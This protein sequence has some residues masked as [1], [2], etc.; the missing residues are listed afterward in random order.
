MYP[1]V[2]KLTFIVALWLLANLTH[3]LW[4]GLRRRGWEQGLTRNADGLLLDALPWSSGHGTT[5][6]LMI[7]GFAD[8]PAVFRMLAA[9]L[10]P[11]QLHCHAMR[12]PG[13]GDA[14]QVAARQ[15]T[16]SL[17]AAIQHEIARLRTSHERVW[18]LGHSLGGG[19]ALLTQLRDP[20]AADGLLLLAPL[21][22]V[23][24]ARSPLLPPHLWFWIAQ[25]ALPLSATFES[26]FAPQVLTHDG[27]AIRYTRD[28]FI[29]FATYRILFQLTHTLGRRAANFTVPLFAAL[30]AT[31][32]IVDTPAAHA[33]LSAATTP[34]RQLITLPESG[35]AIPLEEHLLPHLSQLI[36]AFV[37]VRPKL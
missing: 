19:L 3:R 10:A 26:S 8:S 6:I 36:D 37:N 9:Q 30:A 27:S 2:A 5:A 32:R 31:D 11:Y 13:S 20:T 33:W 28:R 4:I 24:R 16:E 23:S 15:T 22:K 17:L 25:T 1:F 18:L 14:L 12:L 34:R 35:H 29:P 21:L 7:H